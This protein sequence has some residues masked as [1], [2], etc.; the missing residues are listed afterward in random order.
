MKSLW[1][2]VVTL[3]LAA[4]CKEDNPKPLLPD[5]SDVDGATEID[6][7]LCVKETGT[8]PNCFDQASCE[9]STTEDFLNGC[10]DVGCIP[11]DNVARLPRYNNGNLP[12][13]P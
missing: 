11:F 7:N 9:P 3:A 8:P 2:I 1:I 6:A 10:T 5:A 13:L 12:P 4:A